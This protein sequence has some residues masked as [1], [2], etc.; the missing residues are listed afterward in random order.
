MRLIKSLEIGLLKLKPEKFEKLEK[1]IRAIC[2]N[3]WEIVYV[4]SKEALLFYKKRKTLIDKSKA[5]VAAD[6]EKQLK[7]L[8]TDF[9][10]PLI[11]GFAVDDRK[12]IFLFP[13]GKIRVLFKKDVNLKERQEIL[14]RYKDIEVKYLE[15]MKVEIPPDMRSKTQ[16][17]QI[18]PEYVKWAQEKGKEFPKKKT[19]EIETKSLSIPIG[20][21]NLSVDQVQH[22]FDIATEISSHPKVEFATPDVHAFGKDIRFKPLNNIAPPSTWEYNGVTRNLIHRAWELFYPSSEPR[23]PAAWNNLFLSSDCDVAVF[24]INFFDH[25]HIRYKLEGFD[26]ADHDYDPRHPLDPLTEPDTLRYLHGTEMSGVIGGVAQEPPNWYGWKCGVAPGTFIIPFRP[27]SVEEIDFTT[28]EGTDQYIDE[29]SLDWWNALWRLFIISNTKDVNIVNYSGVTNEDLF[30]LS[31]LD[32]WLS[33]ILREGNN[34]FGIFFACS[35]GNNPANPVAFPA[36]LYSTFAVGWGDWETEEVLGNT[37][38]RLDITGATGDFPAYNPDGQ[39]Y[40][41]CFRCGGSSVTSAQVSGVVSLMKMAGSPYLNADEIKSILRVTTRLKPHQLAETNDQG[42]HPQYGYGFLDAFHAVKIAYKNFM[43]PIQAVKISFLPDGTSAILIQASFPSYSSSFPNAPSGVFW[44]LNHQT[45]SQ[46][47]F[48]KHV[49]TDENTRHCEIIIDPIS[50]MGNLLAVGD[51]DGDG[52]DELALQ[53]GYW[54]DSPEHYF[55]IEKYD[56]ADGRW[57]DLGQ[58]YDNVPGIKLIWPRDRS[59]S[60]VFPAQLDGS[61]QDLLVAR[62]EG[63]INAACYDSVNDRWNL[64][65]PQNFTPNLFSPEVRAALPGRIIRSKLLY[66]GRFQRIGNR[67]SLIVIGDVAMRPVS[68]HFPITRFHFPDH[69]LTVSILIYDPATHTYMNL[70]IDNLGNTHTILKKYIP[71]NLRE[72]KIADFDGDGEPEAVVYI[73]DD[74]FCFLDFHRTVNQLSFDG[75]AIYISNVNLE[76]PISALHHG[77]INGNGREEIAYLS[78]SSQGNIVQFLSWN[79]L[80]REWF[81]GSPLLNHLRKENTALDIVVGDFSD[82]GVA[83]IGILMEKPHGNTYKVYHMYKNTFMEFGHW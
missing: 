18:I 5:N 23:T 52:R 47:W 17:K 28:R 10:S 74:T 69:Y 12:D 16:I 42:F 43:R 55:L 35:A 64:I 48:W 19:Q 36:K 78:Q 61:G 39:V 49:R 40:N 11:W 67:D 82:D 8:I 20:I 1:E 62:Q 33:W 83:E 24:D 76:S 27:F 37:G 72:V 63:V 79:P 70:P 51:F 15:D 21:L 66:I 46:G 80:F 73:G 9:K 25:P 38:I 81:N 26:G 41:T 54:V 45:D 75:H 60:Q 65:D 77:D 29:F 14:S 58:N 56:Q 53:L 59:V 3:N 4:K 68:N 32:A 13:S 30:Q 6:L 2:D 57:H 7:Q 22:S 44:C 34:G 50:P 71:R 31:G